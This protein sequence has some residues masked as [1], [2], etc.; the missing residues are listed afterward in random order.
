MAETVINIGLY[1]NSVCEDACCAL[2]YLTCKPEP[3]TAR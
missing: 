3:V 1:P 2:P